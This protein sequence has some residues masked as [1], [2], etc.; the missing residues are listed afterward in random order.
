M[1][2]VVIVGCSGS[3]KSHLSTALARRLGLRVIHADKVFW[4][5]GWTDP[6]NEAYRYEIERLTLDD[7]WIFDGIP[8]RV[9]DIVLP[10]ADTVI[11]LDQPT[12]LCAIRAYGRMFRYFGRTRP[13]MAEG[14]PERF[15]LR[16]W[17]Y[18]SSFNTVMRPRIEGWL[19][20]YA[21]KTPVI[22]L[23]GDRQVAMFL[24]QKA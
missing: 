10:R 3:G 23:K 1:R 18:A 15:S 16:P 8:G 4:K 7:G 14:C 12:M 6:D 17:Q 20:A 2:R 21:P 11:W 22:R 13:D 5:P 9:A 24:S 19:Y